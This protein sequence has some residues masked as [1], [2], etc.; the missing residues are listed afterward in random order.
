MFAEPATAAQPQGHGRL[1]SLGAYVAA[2]AVTVAAVVSQYFVPHL[3]PALE[4]FYRSFLG[5][6]LIVYGIPIFAFALLVGV[7]PLDRFARRPGPAALASLG[8][9]GALSLLSLAVTFALII[10]YLALDPSA[11][12]LLDRPNPVVQE[13]QRNPWF[14]VGFSFAIGAIEETIF[15]GWVFGYWLARGTKVGWVHAVWT[16]ALFAGVHLYYATTYG[17]ASPL[18]YPTLFLLGLAFALAVQASG[19][20]LVWVALL[21]GAND[22]T[23]FLTILSPVVANSIHYGVILVGA[24]VALVLYLR[25]PKVAAAPPAPAFSAP[26]GW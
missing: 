15:R 17:I 14:W 10:V 8:W 18:V 21:H 6:L 20:N 1:G 24:V 7:R 11:L 26:F 16:S 12:D 9:Y 19:G 2:V 4:P 23:A 25:R 22:A 3:L 5:G 13:A